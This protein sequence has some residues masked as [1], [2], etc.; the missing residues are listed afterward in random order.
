MGLTLV[1]PP[2]LEPVVLDDAKAHCRVL[3]NDSNQLLAS[4]ITAA[5]V[6]MEARRYP[7]IACPL[8]T[9]TWALTLD[10]FPP[11][12]RTVIELPMSPVQSITSI[13]TTDVNGN[14]ATVPAANYFLDNTPDLP[15]KARIVAVSP[16]SPLGA[17][18]STV[19]RPANGVTIT[20]VVGFGSTAA[21]IPK[22][23]YVAQLLLVGDLFW[24]R[25][26]PSP[27]TVPLYDLLTSPYRAPGT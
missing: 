15:A 8:I 5:R 7:G 20:Y 18:P 27:G 26:A 19:L 13:Q 16:G 11:D 4:Y 24:N 6:L 3:D 10:E 22:P 21:A 25:E 14:V 23:L 2:V 9:Q 1:T 17:W 12:G